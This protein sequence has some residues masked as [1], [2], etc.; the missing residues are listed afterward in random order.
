MYSFP[1][2]TGLSQCLC[3]LSVSADLHSLRRRARP[4][5]GAFASP[6]PSLDLS[7]S[8]ALCLPTSDCKDLFVALTPR[9]ELFHSCTCSLTHAPPHTLHTLTHSRSRVH[10][11]L[12]TLM[13]A[14]PVTHSLSHTVTRGARLLADAAERTRV[15][16]GRSL[17]WS[18]PLGLTHLPAPTPLKP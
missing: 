4:A 5:S 9:S 2:S 12:Y 14:P 8:L 17:P 11:H 10:R 15:F 3:L 18:A 1:S 6:N 7:M 13:H 16:G